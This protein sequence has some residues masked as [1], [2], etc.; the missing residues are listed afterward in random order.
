LIIGDGATVVTIVPELAAEAAQVTMLQRSPTY[1]A[2]LPN[3]DKNAA[4]L[5]RIFPKKSSL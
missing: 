3:E 4:R 5:K 1:I 2:A